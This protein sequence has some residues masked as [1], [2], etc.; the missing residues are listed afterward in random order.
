[1]K[2]TAYY[3]LL[4]KKG[5][6]M[7]EWKTYEEVSQFLIEK[8]SEEFGLSR[9]EGKQ[10][11]VGKS[12]TEWEVDAKGVREGTDSTVIIE[13][14]RY[15]TSK[16]NQ[17]KL[18]ALAYRISDV[19]ADGGIIVSPLGL[20]SGAKLV[21]DATNIISVEIDANSTI[22]GFSIRFFGNLYIGVRSAQIKIKSYAPTVV[23]SVSK[24]T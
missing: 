14:R 18:G 3:E 11:L 22:D 21:A 20:Q 12:G 1:M 13:A 24:D 8:F 9:V 4:G 7:S 10:K 17:E 16:Q 19:G 23:I 2:F 6:K 5:P 15:T